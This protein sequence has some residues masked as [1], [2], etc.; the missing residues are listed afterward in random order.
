MPIR[1][2]LADPDCRR[3]FHRVFPLCQRTD[4]FDQLAARDELEKAG[5]IVKGQIEAGTRSRYDGARLN[6]QQAQMS[7]QVSKAQ[8]ALRDA[9]SRVAAIAAMPQ[10]QVRVEG[11]LQAADLH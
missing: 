3:T 1:R 6:L 10:W 7:M 4:G 2:C 11:S 9:A 5:S 8:A